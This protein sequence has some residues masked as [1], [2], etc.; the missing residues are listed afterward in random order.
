MIVQ[1][2]LCCVF[3][4]GFAVCCILQ[5]NTVWLWRTEGSMS[6]NS[7]YITARGYVFV[8][9]ISSGLNWC[10]L[11]HTYYWSVADGYCF[12]I[13]LL[14]HRVYPKSH[15]PLRSHSQPT[16]H[17]MIKHYIS[18]VEFYT[19]CPALVSGIH[20]LIQSPMIWTSLHQFSN[21]DLKHSSKHAALNMI[22]IA[23][24]ICLIGRPSSLTYLLTYLLTNKETYGV[25]YNAYTLK[26]SVVVWSYVQLCM[27]IKTSN[28]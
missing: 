2:S 10:R 27:L 8:I 21:P 5:V 15:I 26:M 9:C 1:L 11:L 4:A 16:Q 7:E 12:L 17:S 14:I 24:V 13:I 18:T 3:Y 22:L 28:G 23:L 19:R 25:A 20:S 6:E